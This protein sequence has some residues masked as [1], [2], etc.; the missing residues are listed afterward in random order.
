MK[1]CA[2]YVEDK[3]PLDALSIVGFCISIIGLLVDLFAFICMLADVNLATVLLLVIGMVAGGI[4]GGAG[5]ILSVIGPVLV[6]KKQ[7]RGKAFAIVGIV[8]GA[9]CALFV[10]FS[11][12]Q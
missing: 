2:D 1:K 8:I 3:K 7:K 5:T 9:V 4:I 11:I 6:G 10:L 12:S